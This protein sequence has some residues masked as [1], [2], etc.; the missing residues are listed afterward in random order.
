MT[1]HRTARCACG[2]LR[3]DCRGEPERVSL[4][5]CLACQR[6][7]GSAFGVAAFFRAA[8]TWAEG[9]SATYVRAADSGFTIA[10]HFCPDC[11]STVFWYPAR[12][13]GAVA[14]ALGC[15]ADPGFPPPEQAVFTQHAHP[16]L[17]AIPAGPVP[18]RPPPDTRRD[19]A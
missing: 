15:F 13:P 9:C 19:G 4:C 5:H 10:F 11:G 8:A 12:R 7:T 6:R 16:W 17:S 14:V 3:I 1:T 18:P 2:Q